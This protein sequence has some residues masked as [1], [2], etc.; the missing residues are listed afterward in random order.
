MLFVLSVAT[1]EVRLINVRKPTT[2]DIAEED[3]ENC[4]IVPHTKAVS[5]SGVA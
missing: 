3:M 5:V 2:L 1:R 4:F